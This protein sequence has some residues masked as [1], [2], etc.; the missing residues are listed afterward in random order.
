MLDGRE[1]PERELAQI[2]D[3]LENMDTISGISDEMLTLITELWP[4]QLIKI[5]PARP[6][7]RRGRQLSRP[8]KENPSH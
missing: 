4:D 6:Q 1:L 8:D 2:R 3:Q 5:A 7:W